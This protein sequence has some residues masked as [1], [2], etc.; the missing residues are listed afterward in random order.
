[1]NY[2][3]ILLIFLFF[4]IYGCESPINTKK[5]KLNF[6]IENKYKNAGFALIYNDELDGIKKLEER[7]LNIY[8]KTLKKNSMVKITN[9]NNGISLIAK[10]KSNKVKFSDFYN[11]VLSLRIAEVLELDEN[12][13]YIEIILI[14]KDSTFIAKKAKTFEEES[15]VAEKAPVDGIQISDLNEKKIKKKIIKDKNF[16]YSIK[17]AD[18]YYKDS[19]K[20]M[21]EKIKSESLV[22]NL[23][24]IEMSKTKYRLLIGPFNDIKSLKETFENMSLFNFEN[25]EILKNA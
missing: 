2:K 7:S 14:S 11:S 12:E 16:L 8:H 21:L 23:K 15:V 4:F 20:M 13:P 1:M 19:A 5:E 6:E 22:K 18:F 25:L 17:V 10:V 9:L 3:N 24:I